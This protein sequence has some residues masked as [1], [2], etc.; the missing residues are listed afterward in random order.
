MEIVLVVEERYMPRYV[1]IKDNSCVVT[2]CT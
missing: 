1:A 2:K